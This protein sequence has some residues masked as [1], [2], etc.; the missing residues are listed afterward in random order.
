MLWSSESAEEDGFELE[1]QQ[2]NVV[3]MVESSNPVCT[4]KNKEPHVRERWR[5]A[6]ANEVNQGEGLHLLI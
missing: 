4:S 3:C 1:F 2:H 6:K 5:E